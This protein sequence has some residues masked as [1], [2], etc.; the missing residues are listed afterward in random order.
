MEV[1]RG[2]GGR[3]STKCRPQQM[4]ASAGFRLFVFVLLKLVLIAEGSAWQGPSCSKKYQISQ[5]PACP[6]EPARFRHS[7]R[8]SQPPGGALSQDSIGT[9]LLNPLLKEE[10]NVGPN[11][12][13]CYHQVGIPLG[14]DQKPNLLRAEAFITINILNIQYLDFTSR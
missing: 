1:G 7:R 10:E 6:P 2:G 4:A 14:N 12:T 13:F 11:L 9:T 5:G 3:S 8:P